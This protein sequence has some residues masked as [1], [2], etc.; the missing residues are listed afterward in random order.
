MGFLTSSIGRQSRGVGAGLV[1]PSPI[2]FECHDD[3]GEDEKEDE[4][5]GVVAQVGPL[6]HASQG[7]VLQDGLV[8]CACVWGV[9]SG[10]GGAD[11]VCHSCI[12][13]GGEGRGRGRSRLVRQQHT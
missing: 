6:V 12:V 11:G 13:G 7:V 10:G 3:P 2:L 1:S 4:E 8:I 9:E 5:Q